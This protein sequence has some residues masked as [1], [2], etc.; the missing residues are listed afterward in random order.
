M[1]DPLISTSALSLPPDSDGVNIL[2]STCLELLGFL[3]CGGKEE[4]FALQA[5]RRTIG[6]VLE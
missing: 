4:Q 6:Y 5:Q 3:L 2:S 1:P